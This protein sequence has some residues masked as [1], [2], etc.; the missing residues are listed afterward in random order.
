LW[1][2]ELELLLNIRLFAICLR[3]IKKV[4][5]IQNMKKIF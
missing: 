3:C 2:L 4:W 1:L 5:S